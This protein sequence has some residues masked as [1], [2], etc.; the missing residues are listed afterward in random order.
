MTE[1]RQSM[2]PKK[3]PSTRLR[4]LHQKAETALTTTRA[5]VKKMTPEEVQHLVHE[6]QVHQ[7]ELEMQNEE[8]RRAQA[9]LEVARDRYATLFDFTP[10]GY[11]TL[12]GSGRIL[13]ANLTFCLLLK[14]S[15]RDIIHKKFEKYVDQ[16]DQGVFRLYLDTLKKKSGTHPSD[17]LTLRHATTPHRV[18]LEGSLETMESPGMASLFRI[19]VED[20]T[21][22]ERIETAQEEQK[23]LL[24]LVVGGVTDAIVTTD[25]DERIVLFSEA[26]AN[27]FRC[28]ASSA[29]GQSINRFIPERFRADHHRHHRQFG[30]NPEPFRQMGAAREI[31][32][33]RAD[34]EEFPVEATISQVEV[35]GK[36]K[37]KKLFTV[38]LRDITERRQVQEALKKEQQFIAAI[39]DTAA[40]LMMVIDPQGRIVRFNRACEILT[41]FSCEEVQNQPFWNI[42]VPSTDVEAV[43][44]YFQ[45]F[46]QGQAPS[47]HEHYWTT[48]EKKLRWIAWSNAVLRNEHGAVDFVIATGIDRT[49]QRHAQKALKKEQRFIANV[50]DT[51]GALV[52]ILNPQ[53]RILH[54]NRVCE[55]TVRQSLQ[56]MRGQPFWDLLVI[57]GEDDQGARQV[58]ESYKAGRLPDTFES[59][60]LDKSHRLCWIQWNTTTS[61]K[62]SGAV[63][64]FIVTGIDITGRKHTERLLQQNE[65]QLQ[66]ILDHSPV[67]IWL[68]DLD[69]RYLKVN[70]QF[71]MNVGLSEKEILGKTDRQIFP[72]ERAAQFHQIDQTLLQ[73]RQAYEFEDV[74]SRSDGIHTEIVF[75]FLVTTP[76]GKPY[77]LCGIARDITQRKQ[78]ETILQEA[79]QRL[80]IQKLELRSLASQLLMAQEEERRRISRDL[81]DDVNQRLALLSLK[82][83][84]AQKGLPDIHP[85][86]P[87]LQELYENVADLSDDIRHLAYQYHPSILDDLGLG[88]ALRSLCEDFA[89][90]EGVSVT[91][92]L[93]D[94]ARNFSQAVATCLY[95]VAQESLRN[96]SRHAQASAVHL[97]LREDGQGIS[98]SI[99]DNGQGFEVD[100]LLSRGLGLVSMR[101]RACLVGGTLCVDSQPGQGTIVKVSIPGSTHT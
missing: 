20:V 63:A 95:R 57:S 11:V 42:L 84:T 80:E 32:G 9:E 52:I 8:L 1:L 89:K 96:V 41:G 43:K 88:T 85:V 78:A 36:G 27:M 24:E 61:Y 72:A 44:D 22:W 74:S 76:Q 69:G 29:L 66:A 26:A 12:D 58:L 18:R 40:A 2:S 17:V 56:S 46:I 30:Q 77:A 99:R 7:I 55:H 64:Y 62:K 33:L 39:L 79:S 10:V 59:G 100:G 50:L 34:G 25:E 81:H 65:G 48:K 15:R 5:L 19:A 16:G 28:P 90:W 83:Q 54:M 97:V 60:I 38:V 4:I 101:E 35:K 73:T 21:K 13:E 31:A 3:K 92:E 51:A 14:L 71:E 45:A 37:R 6:L 47:I 67:S 94:G 87:M 82:L 91:W 53:W 49:E 70:R 75:K 68:K 93:T 98:L 23:A 86:T